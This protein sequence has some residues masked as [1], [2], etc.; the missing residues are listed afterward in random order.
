MGPE[1]YAQGKEHCLDEAVVPTGLVQMDTRRARKETLV[2]SVET[3]G[4]ATQQLLQDQ[5]AGLVTMV[6]QLGEQINLASEREKKAADREH[7]LEEQLKHTEE[8][9]KNVAD[10]R[11]ELSDLEKRIENMVTS[12]DRKPRMLEE[13][14][15]SAG[16]PLS[17][18]LSAMDSKP[19]PKWVD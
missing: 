2:N 3:D 5:V 10:R 12:T 19:L 18:L 8:R 1:A 9:E 4:H 13:G 17:D 16:H 7:Q 6:Q 15:S 14:V 11:Q